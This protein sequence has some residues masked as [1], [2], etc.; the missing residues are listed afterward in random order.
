[1]QR[2]AEKHSI[3]IVIRDVEVKVGP[4]G[5]GFFIEMHRSDIQIVAIGEPS[6]PM[7]VSIA[8]YDE[9]PAHPVPKAAL[10]DLFD[11]LQSFILE[12]P[13]V[14]ITEEK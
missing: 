11:D 7:V 1:M 10:D 8:F 5:K 3:K 13:N 14:T 4:S 2:F 12:I 9:D 6:A